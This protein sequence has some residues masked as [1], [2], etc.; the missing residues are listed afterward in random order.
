VRRA[1]YVLEGGQWAFVS[2]DGRRRH[3]R[4]FL[5]FAHV[6]PFA[7]HGSPIEKSI[8]LQGAEARELP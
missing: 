1:A 2:A 7:K 4:G 5:E 6:K 8:R 3:A